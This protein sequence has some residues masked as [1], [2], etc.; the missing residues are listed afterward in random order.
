MKKII[1]IS[2]SAHTECGDCVICVLTEDNKVFIKRSW[3]DG[4]EEQK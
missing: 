3:K 2:V 4:W 1:Q